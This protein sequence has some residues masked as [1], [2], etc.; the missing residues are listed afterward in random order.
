MTAHRPSPSSAPRLSA[1]VNA[2]ASTRNEACKQDRGCAARGFDVPPVHRSLL[3]SGGT[4]A[5]L[6]SGMPWL[7]GLRQR[8]LGRCPSLGLAELEGR[9][10]SQ[11]GSPDLTATV[12]PPCGRSRMEPPALRKSAAALTRSSKLGMPL[13]A[14]G[15][16]VSDR[17]SSLRILSNNVDRD[18]PSNLAASSTRCPARAR[19]ARM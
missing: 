13:R 12:E 18:T 4:H 2:I 6:A 8:R 3:L 5:P 19:T 17:T 1:A 11:S 7:R 15:R 16:Q 14:S 10:Y 9:A